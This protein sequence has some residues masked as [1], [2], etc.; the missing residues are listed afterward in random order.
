[1]NFPKVNNLFW[2]IDYEYIHALR[3]NNQFVVGASPELTTLLTGGPNSTYT[4]GDIN[5]VTNDVNY[6]VTPKLAIGPAFAMMTQLTNDTWN[7]A[8]V[9]NSG[10]FALAAGFSFQYKIVPGVNAQ[11]KYMRTFD[12]RNMP[13][14]NIVWAQLSF[15]FEL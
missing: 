15:P 1:M 10:E 3:G 2:E 12:V 4:T 9:K 14:Y 13:Q 7:G 5:F 11:V 6:F 8:D